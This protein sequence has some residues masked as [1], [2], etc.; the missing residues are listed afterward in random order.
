M[1]KREPSKHDK[2]VGASIIGVFFVMLLAVVLL[3][4]YYQSFGL[5]IGVTENDIDLDGI[6]DNLD[7]CARYSNPEQTDSDGDGIG[8]ECDFCL[9]DPQNDVDNDGICQA[10]DNCPS[11]YNYHQA[12]C[13]ANGI[14]DACEELPEGFVCS[15]DRDEDGVV[16][17][18]DNCPV[19]SNADQYDSEAHPDQ[20]T[21]GTTKLDPSTWLQFSGF[22][23]T[24]SV[25]QPDYLELSVDGIN[26]GNT[27]HY[28]SKI[29]APGQLPE[30]DF[31][32]RFPYTAQLIA[33]VEYQAAIGLADSTGKG[34]TI[35][36]KTS[37]QSQ[38]NFLLEDGII[39]IRKIGNAVTTSLNGNQQTF[40]VAPPLRILVSL[41]SDTKSQ[42]KISMTTASDRIGDSCDI[43]QLALDP[44]QTDSNNNRLSLPYTIDT[45]I[46]D[47]CEDAEADSVIDIRDN[48]P[49]KTNQDQRDSDADG[50]GDVCDDRDADGFLDASDNCPALA[51]Q[52]Q[53]NTDNDQLG[54]VCDSCPA[55]AQNDAD[56]DGI[57]GDVD[58]CGQYNSDQVDCNYNDIGDVCEQSESEG[59]EFF[60]V[61]CTDGDDDGRIHPND[62]CP[63]IA[64]PDQ[65]DCDLDGIG[66]MC[67][68][69]NQCT[70]D[71]DSDG[72]INAEDNCPGASN[73]NQNDCDAN[74]IG[75]L[76]DTQSLC[77]TDSDNDGTVDPADN[78]VNQPNAD[79][80]DLDQ[81]GKGNV[82]DSCPFDAQN[83]QDADGICGDADNC[84][85]LSNA[86]QADSDDDGIG[87]A[88]DALGFVDVDED[89]V[90]DSTDNCPTIGNANQADADED[91]IGSA[92]DACPLDFNND[93]DGD[94]ICGNADNCPAD[95]NVQQG[96]CDEDGIGNACDTDSLCSTDGDED[97]VVDVNDNCA[98]VANA[99]QENADNDNIGDA[100]DAC[101]LDAANDAD[102]D[103]VCGNVDNCASEPNANQF[104]S[105]ED[106]IGDACEVVELLSIQ[107]PAPAAA[108]APSGGGGGGG[109]GGRR[110]SCTPKWTCT[111]WSACDAIG[112]YHYRTC[113]DTNNCADKGLRIEDVP[114][115]DEQDACE[116]EAV[117]LS[118]PTCVD[119]LKNGDE[120]DVDCGGSCAAC[121]LG[122]VCGESA[123]C[124]TGNCLEGV[125]VDE[126]ACVTDDDCFDGVC[127]NGG[128]VAIEAAAQ[129]SEQ[130]LRIWSMAIA[131]F[132]LIIIG[133]VGYRL[134]HRT[135]SSNP[136]VKAI[137][138]YINQVL[139]QGFHPDQ[140]KEYLVQRGWKKELVHQR[141]DSL[142]EKVN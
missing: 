32:V 125:C 33:G 70:V 11:L 72:I 1:K 26:S 22:G 130:P 77:S 36:S 59:E 92:C 64:N 86:D 69:Q 110:G 7:N 73:S 51:N 62:N 50:A 74:G 104:D 94:G 99:G 56:G 16:D 58:N 57:C 142:R 126:Q 66:D 46:G 84:P 55:D 49:T 109:G 39:E 134:H 65:A 30:T 48:C 25:M 12:D 95:N 123:D 127:S 106:G 60:Q 6:T 85:A 4:G 44:A 43:C 120:T 53:S 78:C 20:A 115:P 13:N 132:L 76:C 19:V 141:V 29:S 31:A 102:G 71:T 68:D 63:N 18:L 128:C 41:R 87:D 47:A 37:Q 119:R 88:C 122:G 105:D 101:M 9:N 14:G 79:Q 108:P 3:R 83:D 38:G 8:D 138:D 93:A 28:I 97:G 118:G 67:D 10:V 121:E 91:G 103:G 82:C 117:S 45:K 80:M 24:N 133:G 40:Q 5:A 96:D 113:T 17:N 90:Q 129:G 139:A 89:G 107:E 81:D 124:T 42:A 54:D 23:N 136:A 75:D 34:Y 2:I 111:E 98:E 35:W 52:D 140:V 15:S 100:C 112:G 131:A 116:V 21:F 27:A 135:H 61:T 137:D 114:K